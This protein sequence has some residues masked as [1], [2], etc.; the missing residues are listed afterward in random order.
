MCEATMF[1]TT[2]Q[3]CAITGVP[4]GTLK[5]L[6]AAGSVLA[7]RPGRPGRGHADLW[8]P[9]QVLAL[10]VARGLRG[11]GVPAA[12]AEAV[13]RFLWDL[14]AADLRRHFRAGRTCL[15]L[16]ATPGGTG[17]LPEF[18]P[19]AAILDNEAIDAHAVTALRLGVRPSALDVEAV[20]HFIQKCG[21]KAGGAGGDNH[22]AT[23]MGQSCR[24]DSLPTP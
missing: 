3:L 18:L 20:W 8:S 23:I 22:D 5:R 2:A 4:A 9:E 6:R 16:V 21:G 1:F 19:R 12:D 15:M 24:S 11:C 17:C 14:S 13:L 7:A 10:A